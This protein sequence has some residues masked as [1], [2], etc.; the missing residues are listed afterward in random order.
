VAVV[1]AEDPTVAAAAPSRPGGPAVVRFALAPVVDGTVAD[2]HHDGDH[3]VGPTGPLVAVDELWSGLP[4]DRANV[5]AAAATALA[6]GATAAGVADAARRFRG[7]AHRVQFVAESGGVRW[8]DDSK[9]T[10]PHATLSALAGFES[11]VLIAGGRNKGL[12]LTALGD[13]GARVRAVVGIGE[14]GPEVRDVFADRPGAVATSMVDAV[15][16][17]ADLAGPGDVVLLSPGCA[18]FD[19]YRSYGERG[20]DFVAAVHAHVRQAVP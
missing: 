1:N 8:F 5:L 9:A 16:A 17:A 3:L 18:S 6:G 12:D 14:S 13:A 7:L 15:T 2:Y 20:D 10:A 19:W 11:V 4:H